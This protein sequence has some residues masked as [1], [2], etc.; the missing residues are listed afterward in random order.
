VQQAGSKLG[1]QQFADNAVGRRG[2]QAAHASSKPHGEGWGRKA[3]WA[4]STRWHAEGRV[5]PRMPPVGALGVPPPQF[6]RQQS[7][8]HRETGT[9][10][11]PRGESRR[12]PV[13]ADSQAIGSIREGRQSP[14]Y[15]GPGSRPRAP[16]RRLRPPFGA[17]TVRRVS[18]RVFVPPRGLPG[19][20][21]N[22][23]KPSSGAI[24]PEP[25]FG[26]PGTSACGQV[27]A[28]SLLENGIV[29]AKSQCGQ[30]IRPVRRK[31]G[32]NGWVVRQ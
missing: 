20:S 14:R 1:S 9:R 18:G 17:L 16:V 24:R 27:C 32:R 15:D 29:R 5:A 10:R 21:G 25:S 3:R 8:R 26:L 12:E 7:A 22:R 13:R 11:S 30:F 4:S 31:A 6:A 2:Q 28:R 19:P 23:R